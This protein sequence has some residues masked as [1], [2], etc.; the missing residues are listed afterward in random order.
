MD[1]V[2]TLDRDAADYVVRAVAKDI[3]VLER[4]I[5]QHGRRNNPGAPSIEA[6]RKRH[7]FASRLR[8]QLNAQLEAA[9][10]TNDTDQRTS[11]SDRKPALKSAT[12]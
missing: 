4:K 7:Y 8:A 9:P 3:K 1:P 6:L 11:P 5:R 10:A 12:T 2:I